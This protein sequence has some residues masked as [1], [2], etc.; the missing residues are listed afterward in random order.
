MKL[1]LY[2]DLDNARP[3]V[4]DRDAGG[5][6][7]DALFL[8]CSLRITLG[9]LRYCDQRALSTAPGALVTDRLSGM[10]RELRCPARSDHTHCLS[11]RSRFCNCG[12][13]IRWMN[14]QT[15]HVANPLS[16][17]LWV[18]RI[19]KFLPTTAMLPLSK[20]RKGRVGARPVLICATMDRPAYRPSW[21]ATWATPGNGRP[22]P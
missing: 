19:A 15:S 11:T 5:G 14:A 6:R 13:N 22:F 2:E 12:R 9:C 20:Y 10:R 3:I 21:I 17:I 7:D 8:H 16:R 1:P 18:S 4:A